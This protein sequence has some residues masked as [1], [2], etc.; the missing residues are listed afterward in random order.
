MSAGRFD[1]VALDLDGTLL[2]SD[3]RVS[4]EDAEA[5]RLAISRGVRVVLATARPPRG[6]RWILDELGALKNGERDA[7]TINYNGA[8]VW[9]ATERAAI[10]H[11]PLDARTAREVVAHARA[12]HAETMVSIET[13]D[14]WH[15][16]RHDPALTME[17]SK[18]FPPDYVGPLDDTLARDVTKLML[19]AEPDRVPSI[20]DRVRLFEESRRAGVFVTDPHIVQVAAHGVDKGAALAR[21]A[22][23]LGVDRLR[24]LAIGDAS[25]DIEMLRWAGTGLA[26]ANAEAGAKAASDETLARTNDQSG[27]AFA[28]RRFGVI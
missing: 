23:R 26:M 22:R 15:T 2:T 10:E 21:H 4:P 27:V 7:V 20:R 14:V 13:L 24:V 25:N 12:H 6:V 9:D 1:I 8:L 19:I 17:T 28:L 3:K 16:D 18:L 5:L 11:T